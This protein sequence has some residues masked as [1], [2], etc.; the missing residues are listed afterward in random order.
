MYNK[1]LIGSDGS[2]LA[3]KAIE[4]GLSLGKMAGAKV[5]MLHVAMPQFQ[6]AAFLGEAYVGPSEEDYA[7]ELKA[8]NALADGKAAAAAA[9][10]GIDL[11]VVHVVAAEP[12]RAIIENATALHCDAIVMASHGRGPLTALLLGSD[13]SNV[14][15]HCKLPV[16]VVR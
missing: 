8:I 15:S 13:T 4:A 16:L 2:D 12:W 9:R 1:I 3:D 7:A 5:V 14:L 10:S 11:E 6:P